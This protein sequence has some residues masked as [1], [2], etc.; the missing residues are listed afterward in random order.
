[1][2]TILI[3]LACIPI[4]LGLD[5]LKLTMYSMAITALI[6]PIVVLPFLVL[7]NDPHYVGQHV[8]GRL[9]NGV[10]F[11]VIMMA[12]IIAPVSIPLVIAGGQ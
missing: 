3:F 8:N 7:M 6:L 12:S 2:Y 1:M 10:V 5:P 4:A 11:F 9:G